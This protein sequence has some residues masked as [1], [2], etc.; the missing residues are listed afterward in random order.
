MKKLLITSA[1]FFAASTALFAQSLTVSAPGYS[2]AKLFDASPGFTIGGLAASPA[3]DLFYIE[4]DSAFTAPSQLYRRMAG[5]GYATATPLFSFGA[6]IFGSFV[7]WESGTVFFGENSTGV[8]RALLPN[9][10][11]D[12][13]GTVGGNY[14][15]AFSGGVLHLSHNAGGFT[16]LNKVSRFN[17]LPDGGGGLMLDAADLIVDT[18][19]DYSGALVFDAGGNLFYGGS[20]DY[21]QPHLHRFSAA[22][23]AAAAGAGLAQTLDLPHQY[24]ANGANAYLAYDGA[25]KIWQSNFGTLS[26]IGTAL[27][28]SVAI[29]SSPDFGIGHLDV[30]DG[31]LFVAVTNSAYTQSSV[32]AVVPEPGTAG[33]LALGFAA[34]TGRV[35]RED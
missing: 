32:Y 28:G 27:P 11:I 30:A 12:L 4:S 14:D 19:S 18:P 2:G 13:L 5:D 17:L 7:R 6:S 34:L 3:G 33:L 23:V 20:G 35:R 21:G 25:G 31:T 8:I 1:A 15:A 24:L 16:P 29:G 10:T 26:R 9:L 22:E